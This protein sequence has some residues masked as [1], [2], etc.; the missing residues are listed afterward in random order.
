MEEQMS[1]YKSAYI[2]NLFALLS[3]LTVFGH[4]IDQCLSNSWV[5]KGLFLF[6]FSFHMP[7][8]FFLA[9]AIFK[10][11]EDDRRTVWQMAGFSLC[12]Y[13][14]M[15][16]V[17]SAAKVLLGGKLSFSLLTESGAPWIFLSVALCFLLAYCL[18][19]VDKRVLLAGSFLLA[20]LGG[21]IEAVGDFLTLSRA[22]VFS[23]F[24]I[25]GWMLGLERTERTTS[26]KWLRLSG[27]AVLA[28]AL[29]VMVLFTKRCYFLRTLFTGRNPY[30]KLGS[31]A[32]RGPLYRIFTYCASTALVASVL[33]VAP[34]KSLG[35][36]VDS[37]G[38]GFV[39]IYFLH[40][41][42]L[43][44]LTGL[45][46]YDLLDQLLGWKLG[47]VAW[48]I[49]ALICVCVL[50]L[51]V[52]ARPFG[53]IYRGVGNI[54]KLSRQVGE[55]LLPIDS[56]KKCFFWYTA[57]FIILFSVCYWI[58]RENDKTFIYQTDAIFFHIEGLMVYG[59]YLRKLIL[60]LFQGKF[61]FSQF[62]FHIGL[63]MDALLFALPSYA[64]PLNLFSVFV[65]SAYTHYLYS[66]L[67][68]VRIYLI[69]IAFLTY[70]LY[71][72][73]DHF[74]S[75]IAAIVYTFCNYIFTALR[76]TYFLTGMIYLPLLL[77]GVEE[78]LRH[79]KT[80]RIF[81]ITVFVSVISSYYFLWMNTI[82]CVFY[83]V[84]RYFETNRREIKSFLIN[85]FAAIKGYLLGLGLGAISLLPNVIVF[86]NSNRENVTIIDQGSWPLYTNNYMRRFFV[87]LITPL[88]GPG[89]PG[90]WTKL[91]FI[92]IS[93]ICLLILFISVKK[94]VALKVGYAI[95]TVSLLL[96]ACAL[97]MMAFSSLTTRW[98]Y[99]FAFP[100]A[101]VVAVGLENVPTLTKRNFGLVFVGI[102]VYV[103]YVAFTPQAQNVY[104]FVGV[105]LL[106]LTFICVYIAKETGFSTRR[107]QV[108]LIAIVSLG[109]AVNIY[110][111]LSPQY[112]DIV[113]EFISSEKFVEIQ[114]QSPYALFKDAPDKDFY[115]IDADGLF[116][117]H[118]NSSI[119]SK[120]NSTSLFY[121][122]MDR[123]YIRYMQELENADYQNMWRVGGHDSR[124]FL[125]AMNQVKYWTTKANGVPTPY[126]YESIS[127]GADADNTYYNTMFLP[128]GF[129]YDSVIT[130]DTFEPLTPLE[131]QEAFMQAVLLENGGTNETDKELIYTSFPIKYEVI[132][133]NGISVKKNIYTVK[134]N[135]TLQIQFDQQ[136][137][138]EYYLRF[139]NFNI[140]DNGAETW[141]ISVKNDENGDTNT[142]KVVSS[143]DTFSGPNL[144]TDFTV[145]LGYT[146]SAGIATYTITFPAKGTF[147]L[148]GLEVY[149]QSM[150]NYEAYVEKLSENTLENL[151]IG[152]SRVKGTI[153][154]D[155]DKILYYSIPYS[156][157]WKATVDGKPVEIQRANIAFMAIPLE[158]GDHEVVLNYTTPGL[159][160]GG[161]IS[162]I[163]ILIFLFAFKR[164]KHSNDSGERNV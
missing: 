48:I 155:K 26:K 151:E 146:E 21:Y 103:F 147:T 95:T 107:A 37:I 80:S 52:L 1:F 138:A 128:L 132:S 97:V 124:A 161:G 60:G 87:Y 119:V 137:N 141:I 25:L 117:N 122:A 72:K 22:I 70:C 67:A 159:A 84:L 105:I 6:I 42:I 153:S 162:A 133:N 92:S 14:L 62:D 53:A 51:R 61:F 127:V 65:P 110:M 29:L 120:V 81:A 35:K 58:F 143:T 149:A 125:L 10:R 112:G 9:G 31:R 82:F 77:I 76:H 16:L 28:L 39:Q 54:H 2:R 93:L 98:S 56:K 55:T 142:W 104:S 99:V 11:V 59:E 118:Y 5:S 23:P 109:A 135:A 136:E 79:K 17:T 145:N 15:K 158:A 36:I 63:G 27:L 33:A 101:V 114:A 148:D 3:V 75:Y 123:N 126:G 47:R 57:T 85:T 18:R 152:L 115:R 164:K 41:P 100:T 34:R 96:P 71:M 144:I 40:R 129:T 90:N 108:L 139:N 89:G 94:H 160:A 66:A 4:F 45:G 86:L 30:A 64:E 38:T 131:K 13:V 68:V 44:I 134:K 46:V 73:K 163:S 88:K 43:Y 154:L 91:G 19:N 24:F 69:G 102:C 121:N 113:N 50:S 156:T 150:D 49:C 111:T 83:F 130:E 106:L 8:L 32:A 74:S 20:V 157:G 12:L 140:D 78:T 116:D 7:L